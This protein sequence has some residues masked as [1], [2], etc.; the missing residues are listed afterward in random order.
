LEGDEGA[1]SRPPPPVI[2][3]H[4]LVGINSTTRHL[5][6]LVPSHDSR[7]SQEPTSLELTSA[8]PLVAIFLTHAPTFLPYSHLPTLIALASAA[9]PS[10]IATRLVPLTPFSETN[11]SEALGI[12]RAGAVGV[13]KDAP[14]SGPLMD[15]VREH[16]EPVDVPWVREVSAGEWLGTKILV[17]EESREQKTGSIEK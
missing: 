6:A 4:I 9:Q 5:E 14:G 11:L 8:K 2:A 10:R 7:P 3:E 12:A 1:P 16:V 13:F 15:Y 17:G